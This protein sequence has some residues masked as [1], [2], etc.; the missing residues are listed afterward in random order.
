MAILVFATITDVERTV[1]RYHLLSVLVTVMLYCFSDVFWQFA[2]SGVWV[3]RTI[4]TRNLTNIISYILMIGC[5]HTISRYLFSIWELA[6]IKF[7]R[8]RKYVFIPFFILA[9]FVLT[10]PLTHLVFSFDSDCRIIKGPLYSVLMVFLFGYLISFGILSLIF[11]FSTENDFE[12]EQYKLVIL[13][14]IPVFFGGLV[15]YNIW[16]APGFAIGLTL[17]TFIIYIFQMRELISLDALTG[18]KNRRQG[19]RFF[20]EQIRRINE[21]PHSTLECLYLFM[22]DLNRFKSINDTYGHNEGDKALIATAE[23]IKEACSHIRRRC[24]MSR[25]GGDEFVI[26]VVFTPEEA[27]FL[28]EKIKR[29]IEVKNKE[30]G[31]P[32]KISISVG[33]TYYK[34]EYKDFRTFFLHADRLMYEMKEIAH[35]EEANPS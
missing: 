23:V 21:E 31:T 32:Y 6:G 12:K 22:M 11:Y 3:P 18:I 1:R 10:T 25:F 2:Y 34:K 27:H 7:S 30:L 29:L 4:F 35:S 24:I 20:T 17:A 15:R 28:S 13:Y 9:L 5:T 14:A 8:I 26:G 16:A 19:E 33:F